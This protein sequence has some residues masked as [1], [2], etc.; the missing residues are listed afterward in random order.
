MN[1]KNPR[2]ANLGGFC[3]STAGL[4]PVLMP[5]GSA[6]GDGCRVSRWPEPVC[7]PTWA[8]PGTAWCGACRHP[9]SIICI[10]GSY[11]GAGRGNVRRKNGFRFCTTTV[12]KG[13]TA[14][15][16]R[17]VRN[18]CSARIPLSA[19]WWI[20]CQP[21]EGFSSRTGCMERSSKAGMF[22]GDPPGEAGFVRWIIG[23]ARGLCWL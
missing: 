10:A 2:G 15:L 3:C 23:M 17:G 21:P 16:R 9:G 4:T 20:A 8:P 13:T 18:N 19:V 14:R 1:A 5:I 22:A 12:S 6:R 11:G 7:F